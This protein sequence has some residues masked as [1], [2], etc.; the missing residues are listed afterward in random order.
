MNG[1][2][3]M[4]WWMALLGSIATIALI[5]TAFGLMLSIV[6]PADA[7][8]RVGAILGIVIVLIFILSVVA[9]VWSGMS[10]WQQI[11]LAAI[12]IAF[13]K[14]RRPRRQPCRGE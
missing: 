7:L 1:S 6:K 10:L 12:A 14:W 9:S 5:L 4:Q 11:G 3:F 2:N 8:K 13:L